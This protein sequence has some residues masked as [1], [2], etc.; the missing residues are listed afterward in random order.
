MWLVCAGTHMNWFILHPGTGPCLRA[1]GCVL[2]V[3]THVGLLGLAEGHV[4][5]GG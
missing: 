3:C 5:R 4:Y 1:H 2:H